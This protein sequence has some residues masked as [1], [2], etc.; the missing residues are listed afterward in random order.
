MENKLFFLIAYLHIFVILVY[1]EP[2]LNLLAL[3]IIE[4]IYFRLLVN[5]SVFYLFLYNSA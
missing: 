3:L 2:T 1:D 5:V 4:L